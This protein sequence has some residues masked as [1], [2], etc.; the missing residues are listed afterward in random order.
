MW[1]ARTADELR[2]FF[3]SRRIRIFCV[4]SCLE[5]GYGPLGEMR[6]KALFCITTVKMVSKMHGCLFIYLFSFPLQSTI[7]T[8]YRLISHNLRWKITDMHWAVFSHF[9][10]G[11]FDCLCTRQSTSSMFLTSEK[12]LHVQSCNLSFI[13][14]VIQ[15]IYS[16]RLRYGKR[17]RINRQNPCAFYTVHQLQYS[18]MLQDNHFN[19]KEHHCSITLKWPSVFSGGKLVFTWDGV[20]AQSLSF[21][22]RF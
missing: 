3:N 4:A 1:A 18:V 19:V 11:I 20:S 9:T 12:K 6:R 21:L 22:T 17:C 5:N 2:S 10:R 7:L 13:L 14:N 15:A 16:W 8:A